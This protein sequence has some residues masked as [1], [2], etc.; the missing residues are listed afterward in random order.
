[1]PFSPPT[2]KPKDEA[3][4]LSMGGERCACMCGGTGVSLQ[5]DEGGTKFYF[6]HDEFGCVHTGF[7]EMSHQ[8]VLR[9]KC[10][11]GTEVEC[12]EH[13]EIPNQFTFLCPTCGKSTTLVSKPCSK[14]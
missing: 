4:A 5:L 7:Y 3:D 8:P 14:E 6:V 13:P 12:H 2:R 11:C 10:E 9:T 1:M